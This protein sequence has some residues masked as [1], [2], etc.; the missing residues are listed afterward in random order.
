VLAPVIRVP[1]IVSSVMVSF[2]KVSGLPS[3]IT[4]NLNSAVDRAVTSLVPS[5]VLPATFSTVR[6]YVPCCIALCESVQEPVHRPTS[7]YGSTAG[8]WDHATVVIAP[9]RTSSR[10]VQGYLASSSMLLA[11]G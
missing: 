5:T 6:D 1:S 4:T 7:D 2:P 3:S 9:R 10:Q 11:E 8:V